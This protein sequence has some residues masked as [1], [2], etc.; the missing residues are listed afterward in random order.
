MTNRWDALLA[1]QEHDTITD[2]LE[3]RKATLPDRGELERVMARNPFPEAE[4]DPKTLH[5]GFLASVPNNPDLDKL[6]TLKSDT[7]RFRLIDT[8]FYL[9]APDGIGRSK[10]AA[11][12]ERLLGVPMTDR[13]W[14]TVVKL[15]EMANEL[16]AA[17][18]SR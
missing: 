5:L 9:H 11:R 16:Q 8:V 12:A 14:R 17:T 2:Q 7:E 15:R 4:S 6:E 10:L 18:P 3:H 1:V 13:N